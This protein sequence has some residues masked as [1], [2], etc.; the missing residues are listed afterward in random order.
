MVRLKEF[1]RPDRAK[2]QAGQKFLAC[3]LLSRPEPNRAFKISAPGVSGVDTGCASFV[4]V[5]GPRT[6]NDLTL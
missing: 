5:F 4:F 2:K 6:V 3:A 1:V